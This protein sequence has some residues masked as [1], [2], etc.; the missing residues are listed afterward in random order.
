MQ[1]ALVSRRF[2]RG[3]EVTTTI[4]R[5]SRHVRLFLALMFIQGEDWFLV[6]IEGGGF[7]LI[8]F[9]AIVIVMG[10]WCRK[11]ILHK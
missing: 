10:S 6:L 8:A 9:W 4:L 7:L 11:A 3:G 2:W 5:S 1:L